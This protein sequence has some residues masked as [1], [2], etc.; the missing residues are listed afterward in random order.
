MSLSR[1]VDLYVHDIVAANARNVPDRPALVCGEREYTWKELWE[2]VQALARGLAAQGVVRGSCVAALDRNSDALVLLYH[3]VGSL[4]ASLYPISVLL[5]ANE[6]A[7]LLSNARPALLVAGPGYEDLAEAAAA[8]ATPPPR[9]VYRAQARQGGLHWDDISDGP[10]MADPPAP[11]SWD[12]THLLLHTSGTTGLP[13]SVA[14]SHRRS[15]V[16][17][18]AA[19]TSIGARS[20]DRYYS[21]TPLF[22][23]G[24]WDWI[25]VFF[26]QRACVVLA[27]RFDAAR[28][29]ED[30]VRHRCTV[31]PFFPVTLRALIDHEKFRTAD[32]SAVRLIG[33]GGMDPSNV[34]QTALGAFAERGAKDVGVVLPYGMTE[35][36]PFISIAQPHESVAHPLSVGGAV[37]GVEI[38]L[39]DDD[40]VEVGEGEVGEVCLRT[41]CLMTEYLDNPEA[42]AEAFRGD[43]L[44]TGDLARKTAAGIFQIVDRKK[45]MIRTGGENVFAK[46]VEEVLSRH[47]S[48][49]ECAVVGTPHPEFGET[50]VA[51]VVPEHSYADGEELRAFV[52]ERIAGFKTPKKIV[53][54]DAMP[55]TPLGKVAKKELKILVENPSEL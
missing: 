25:K 33:Y 48:V 31:L 29:I 36:G 4:G 34:L 54:L 50:V 21:N 39:L 28:M 9:L 45:D 35:A 16:D 43:W 42:T 1:D 17:G 40:M 46:E 5:R 20:S 22:H 47:P 38:C 2:G 14:I 19:A 44:H 7:A 32:F 6:V 30:A 49:K 10:Q 13:K 52:R 27:E 18:L 8:L 15:V 12:D 53:F 55:R 41:P 26:M 37:P 11:R 3:A 51:V 23:T 24:A